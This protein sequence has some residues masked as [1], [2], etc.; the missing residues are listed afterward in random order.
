M[1][2]FGIRS[3]LSAMTLAMV[4]GSVGVANAQ[5]PSPTE[6]A[7]ATAKTKGDHEAIAAA[8]EKAAVSAKADAKKH[9]DLGEAYH[10]SSMDRGGGSHG[11]ASH[12]EKLATLYDQAAEENLALAKAHKEAAADI[13]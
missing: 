7:V 5:T 8:Y 4:M 1:K 13:K 10:R 6:K 9:R 2:R 11:M 3:L 12:C